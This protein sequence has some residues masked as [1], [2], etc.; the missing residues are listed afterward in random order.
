MNHFA[1]TDP[2]AQLSLQ[3]PFRKGVL[4]LRRWTKDEDERVIEA[5]QILG[6]SA[7]WAQIADMVTGR[8][9]AECR[10][11]FHNNLVYSAPWRKRAP[12]TTFDLKEALSDDARAL[13]EFSFDAI[14]GL[15]E[16]AHL[17][18]VVT[19]DDGHD[20]LSSLLLQGG[21]Y[22]SA[23]DELEQLE[24]LEQLEMPSA[25]PSA[26]CV[27]VQ[28]QEQHTEPSSPL[29]GVVRFKETSVHG[30]RLDSIRKNN[31]SISKAV[32]C[33]PITKL[34]YLNH[35]SPRQESLSSLF[36]KVNARM[37]SPPKPK[38]SRRSAPLGCSTE[39]M[40]PIP[41]VSAGI[42]FNSAAI[43]Y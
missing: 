35:S 36:K 3:S 42:V 25:A 6:E 41:G 39:S 33:M 24:Q 37:A 1:L 22:P 16:Q 26:V 29:R 32:L 2:K 31:G 15:G 20:A 28:E 7:P 23:V 34:S 14:L 18:S 21:L 43:R 12:S 8:S 17:G 30:R 27:G 38:R 4:K 13:E 5:R 19:A 9:G 40:E 11:R 10:D